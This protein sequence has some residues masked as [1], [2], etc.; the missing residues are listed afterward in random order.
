MATSAFPPAGEF[1]SIALVRHFLDLAAGQGY[2]TNALLA[3]AGLDK[4]RLANDDGWLP[5]AQGAPMLHAVLESSGDPLIS[6]KLSQR[7]F[8]S[9][10]GIVG[11]LLENSPTLK[12]AILSLMRYERLLSTVAVS[13]LDY[14]PGEVSWSIDC[15]TADPVLDRQ[16]EEFHIGVRYLFMRMVKE[17]LSNIVSS[18]HFRYPAPTDP[19]QLAVYHAI[20]D[21][22]VK[23]DQAH[24]ALALRLPALA[25]QLHQMA[26][27]LKQTLEAYADRKLAEMMGA[28]NG[29]VLA[30]ARAQLSALL[31][32]GHASRER[33]AEYLGVSGRHLARQLAA[34]GSSYG[35]LLDELRLEVAHKL[36]SDSS[37]TISEIGQ[38]LGFSDGPSFSRWFR[39]RT[40]ATPRDYRQRPG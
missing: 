8:I 5:V 27:G 7:S 22:P 21:C 32:C 1:V 24:S 37:K 28:A 3:V 2:S 4:E 13:H 35:K 9:G 26:P 30:Q 40:D 10:F 38:Q 20:F 29:S 17:K 33:L 19:E 39:Q 18:V 36:L 15:R 16:V 6:L 31:Y 25:F 11:Y 34:E 12:S 14:L 23:F